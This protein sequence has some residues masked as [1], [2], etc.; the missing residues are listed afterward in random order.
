M[1]SCVTTVEEALPP[2]EEMGPCRHGTCAPSDIRPRGTVGHSSQC[3]RRP[4]EGSSA[5]RPGSQSMKG[6][7]FAMFFRATYCEPP[8]LSCKCHRKSLTEPFQTTHHSTGHRHNCLNSRWEFESAGE[9]CHDCQVG[10]MARFSTTTS[11]NPFVAIFESGNI[12]R[13]SHGNDPSSIHVGSFLLSKA[14][15]PNASGE[16]DK[17]KSTTPSEHK[18]FGSDLSSSWDTRILW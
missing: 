18:S 3:P 11:W 7:N 17:S 6:K 13:S 2:D 16:S 5:T 12:N 10:D 8:C 9:I 14:H 1:C 15:R 4:D